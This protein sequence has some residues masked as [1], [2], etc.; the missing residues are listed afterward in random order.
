MKHKVNLPNADITAFFK[1]VLVEEKS[2]NFLKD[3]KEIFINNRYLATLEKKL[4]A[5][6]KANSDVK[7]ELVIDAI[8][9]RLILEIRKHNIPFPGKYTS[10]EDAKNDF[11]VLLKYQPSTENQTKYNTHKG[12]EGLIAAGY[13]LE[14]EM[15]KT[16]TQCSASIHDQWVKTEALYTALKKY[17]K[18]A[19]YKSSISADN[20]GLAQNM[21]FNYPVGN[22]RPTVL[23]D[24]IPYIKRNYPD[25]KCESIVDPCGGFGGRLIGLL[26]LPECQ[27]IV[28]NDVNSDLIEGYQQIA[29][30]FNPSNKVVRFLAKPAEELTKQDICPDNKKHD[31]METCPPYFDL[32]LYAGNANQ[33]SWKRYPKVTEFNKNFLYRFILN[34]RENIKLGGF[35]AITLGDYK[36][37]NKKIKFS[38][39]IGGDEKGFIRLVEPCKQFLSQNGFI[40]D[41]VKRYYPQRAAKKKFLCR[42]KLF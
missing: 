9:M 41:D 17:L 4:P 21:R 6:I 39:S 12:E 29:T 27:T 30:H 26:A 20:R 32:E 14:K 34:I 40:L 19:L 7:K 36:L 31:L 23:L 13:F 3:E 15:L 5:A 11:E 10:F 33:Q 42:K 38:A 18:Y 24:T 37:M 25:F 8:A 2:E 1:K 22:Y 28:Y 16:R 35:V